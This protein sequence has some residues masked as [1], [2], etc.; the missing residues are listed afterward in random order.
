MLTEDQVVYLLKH[1]KLKTPQWCTLRTLQVVHAQA[2]LTI[3]LLTFEMVEGKSPI[4]Y[5]LQ[6][7]LDQSRGTVLKLLTRC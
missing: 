3:K 7:Q 1:L 2:H 6:Q 5:L 4:L